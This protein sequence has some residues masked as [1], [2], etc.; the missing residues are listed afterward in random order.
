MTGRNSKFYPEVRTPLQSR[1]TAKEEID[2]NILYLYY[3]RL[4]SMS[5]SSRNGNEKTDL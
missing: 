3:D 5:K 1:I 2:E 4:L